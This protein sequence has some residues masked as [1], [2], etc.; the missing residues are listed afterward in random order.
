[1]ASPSYCRGTG[2]TACREKRTL[3]KQ[4]CLTGV[5]FSAIHTV[6]GKSNVLVMLVN[7]GV[8]SGVV[9]EVGWYAGPVVDTYIPNEL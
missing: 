9:T 1:M 4:H 7:P 2:V 5:A 3:D 8:M 6:Q